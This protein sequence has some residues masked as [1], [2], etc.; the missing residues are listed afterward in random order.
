MN[1][2]I[3]ALTPIAQVLAR[4]AAMT[5]PVEPFSIP[6]ED[7]P[8][9][10]LAADVAAPA[11]VPATAVALWDGWA[12][13]AD[14][15]ADAGPYAPVL[16]HSP[17]A[18]VDA[19]TAMPDGTD[20]VLP[21]DA[22][23]GAEIHA[24]ATAGDGVLAAGADMAKGQVLRRA[25]HRLLATDAAVIQAA[26]YKEIAIREPLVRVVNFGERH[27]E[28]AI[29]RACGLRGAAL[30]VFDSLEKATQNSDIIIGIGGT[31]AGR[32]DTAVEEL[33][34]LGQV[35]FHGFGIS[36]GE[37]AALGTAAGIPVLLLPARLDAALSVFLIVGDALL[38]ARTG[39]PISPGMPVRL[40]R[41]ITSTVGLVEIVP[42]RR[43]DDGVAPLASGHWP[44]ET[45][46]RA[47]GWVAVP[48]ESEGYA[49]GATLDMRPFP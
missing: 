11:K 39:A 46:A 47:D 22:V 31:G 26:G 8:G 34:R 2:R 12:V 20:A 28:S 43:V 19:G 41:K 35:D 9:S 29:S 32:N 42:V 21:P 30:M 49:P 38:R 44:L 25:G 40:A 24:S 3:S 23:S 7:S 48:A 17:P 15:V 37:A 1:P 4:I 10:I 18:W 6:I 27:V 13:R 16:L 14:A 5:T 33:A 36:P 45:L